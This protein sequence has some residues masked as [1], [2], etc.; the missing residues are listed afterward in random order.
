M[1]PKTTAPVPPKVLARY[2]T[3]RAPVRD[4]RF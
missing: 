3:D 4:G 1:N 2:F